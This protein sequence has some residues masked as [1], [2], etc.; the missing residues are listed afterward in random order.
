M[1]D[2]KKGQRQFKLLELFPK[3]LFVVLFLLA[4]TVVSAQNK[5][6][7]GLVVDQSSQPIIGANI[8]VEGTTNG[9]ITDLDG[10]FTLADV[11]PNAKLRVSYI[12]YVTQ[13]ISV[14]EKATFRIILKEDAEALD[15]VVVVGYGV[16]K[17][18]DVT[19]AMSRVDQKE[20]KA[21]PVKDA[22]QAMQGKTAGVDIT[23]NQRP[24]ETGSIK[25]RGVRSLN[26]DQNPLYVVDGMVLQSGGI[27]NINPS[28]IESIDILKDASATA[29]YG[30]RGA[31]GVILVTTKHGKEGKVTLNYSGSVTIEKMYDVT[32]YMNAGEWLDYARLAKYNMGTYTSATP[33]YDADFATW[34]SVSASFANIEKGWSNN[35]TEWDSS[36]VGN[37]DWGKYGKQTGLST[38]HTISASGGSEKYQAYGSFGY[39]RQEGT[40]PGQLF[41]RYTAK[42]SFDASPIKSFKMGTS[43]NISWGDQDY[44]YSFARSVTGAG[45]LYSALKGMLPWTVPYDENGDYIRNPAAGD[46]NIINPINELKYTTNNR[47]TF[48][49]AGSFYAQLDFGEIWKPLKGLKVRTQFG[50]E[51]KYYR[52]GIFYA[53]E[54]INGDGNN[55]AA[56]NNY[57]TRAWTLDNLVYYDRTIA[58]DHKIGL[59]LMQSASDYHYEY[60]EMKATDVASSSEMWYN[61]YSAGELG[62]FGTGLTEKQ[63]ESYMMRAN[64][65]YKEKYLLTASV[66]WDGA[67]QLAEGNKWACFPSLALGWRIDQEKFMKDIKWLSAL[68]LRLG[69]GTTGN[70]AISAYATKGALTSLYY[71]WGTTSSTL[72][73][74]ASDPSQKD[75][76]KMANNNL[77]WESTTQYNVGMD[78]GF[79]NGRING[80]LDVYKTKT[81]DLLMAMSIPSLTGYTSTYANV[82]KTEGWGIDF[83][84]N[85]VNVKTPNFTWITNLTWSKDKS[86]IT[87]LANDN[88]EDVSNLW[89]VGKEIGVY[90]DYVYD[91]IWKTSEA[92]Q[93]AK[94]GRKPGQIKVKDLNADGI[95]DANNDK[96]IVGTDRPDWSGGITNTFN[97]KNFELSFFIYTR[98]GS[99][100]KSGALTLD[101]RFMQRKIDYWVAGTNEGA[102]YYSPGSNGEGADTYSS[103]MNYQDG[104]F[105]KMRNINFGYNFTPKQLKNTGLGSLKI[106]AQCM[107]PF[108]IYKKCD[109]LDADLSNYD[110]NTVTTGSPI[111]TRGLVFGVNV[112]F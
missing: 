48:R 45:D 84:I 52:T 69:M 32:K 90:Y 63:M 36:K 95:I 49:A 17:K 33:S 81:K 102:K 19:G 6:I 58:N 26:A 56:Y 94:Y 15:E 98:W 88:T 68:K 91:G 86:K 106:Y 85:T 28:D 70:S 14:L 78:Y 112:G 29:I 87:E 38:E 39:L 64:Y 20:L 43:M 30:S 23:T 96:K 80:S 107:N 34:G 46:V 18:S 77:T 1:K 108:M 59:T 104:S 53:A 50:P 10:N 57:Q 71:N 67:S 111:T 89:F 22:L 100:F 99:T 66:R 41:R 103:S 55:T 35:N 16:Q 47:Q 79:L 7:K 3:L 25:V 31:N 8:L 9:T 12:G 101:G 110:N 21:M 60:G 11:A 2:S 109:Y 62:S 75:P 72:G 105:I 93:A 13:M 24:G 4:S 5:S 61:L 37:Y 83:Q 51:F 82:G 73:Y 76:A 27:D 74:V 40:Q 44:G 97:Y 42:T 54:G 65:S 92:D